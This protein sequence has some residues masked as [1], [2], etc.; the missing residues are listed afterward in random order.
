VAVAWILSEGTKRPQRD[1]RER[2]EPDD[3][4]EPRDNDG[5]F[6]TIEGCKSPVVIGAPSGQ[7]IS[8]SAR[9]A[10]PGVRPGVL[11]DQSAEEMR[12]FVTA[13]SVRG[14][15]R[16]EVFLKLSGLED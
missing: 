7:P 3:L 12:H 10:V 4:P 11:K 2:P 5:E 14:R 9:A 16:F 13:S 6:V 1:G 15:S 8:S